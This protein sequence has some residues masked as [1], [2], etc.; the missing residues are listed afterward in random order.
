MTEQHLLTVFLNSGI[1]FE[2]VHALRRLF[3]LHPKE[4]LESRS[5]P[6]H[7]METVLEWQI[8]EN[9]PLE[10]SHKFLAAALEK[11]NLSASIPALQGAERFTAVGN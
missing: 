8:R 10:E 3:N 5:P 7:A 11:I 2:N 9:I 4:F 6:L 1:T